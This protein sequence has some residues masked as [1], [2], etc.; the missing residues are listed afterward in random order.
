MSARFI[1]VRSK[2]SAASTLFSGSSGST[3]YTSKFVSTKQLVFALGIKVLSPAPIL[4]DS[5]ISRSSGKF[6]DHVQIALRV[7]SDFALNQ[8]SDKFRQTFAATGCLNASSGR[9]SIIQS[10]SDILHGSALK[11]RY[12][13]SV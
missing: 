9:N 7:P 10:Y 3:V 13:V 11:H 12:C 2:M 8:L 5:R 4:A 6:P 1:I